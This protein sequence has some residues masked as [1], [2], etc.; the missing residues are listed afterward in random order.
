ML[1]ALN[2]PK[3]AKDELNYPLELVEKIQRG[4]AL[5]NEDG[6]AAGDE[7]DP[8]A[9]KLTDD[10]KL[11]MEMFGEGKYHLIPSFFRT[12][13]Y[14]KKQKREFSVV[15]RTFGKCLNKVVWEFNKF[16]SGTHPCYSGRNGTPLIKFDGSKNAKDL[17]LRDPAQMG[18]FVRGSSEAR[19]TKLVQGT[20]DRPDMHLE[21]E[22]QIR[23]ALDDDKYEDCTFHGETIQQYSAMLDA[24]KKFSSMAI[25]D[26]YSNWKENDFHREVA[27]VLFLDQADYNTQHIFFDDHADE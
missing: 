11:L 20:F 23:D 12:L 13:I 22:G 19:D 7:D 9:K 16:C 14:L 4:D 5:W 24:L 3:G 27:K 10:E 15:F 25:S 26:D 21:D 1:K 6:E 2:L 18:F 8:D 17:R